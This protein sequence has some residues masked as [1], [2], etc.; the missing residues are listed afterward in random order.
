MKNNQ[1]FGKIK[2]FTNSGRNWI[3]VLCL[4]LTTPGNFII[5]FVLI[6]KVMTLT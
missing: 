1:V 2:N 3:C 6:T 4:H 5:I